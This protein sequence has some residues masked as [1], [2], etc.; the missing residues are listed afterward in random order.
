MITHKDIELLDAIKAVVEKARGNIKP[1]TDPNHIT[2]TDYE[3]GATK[4]RAF[5][6]IQVLIYAKE[7][8]K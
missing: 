7:S 1:P 5:D 4:I 3:N 8:K 2:E 6:E